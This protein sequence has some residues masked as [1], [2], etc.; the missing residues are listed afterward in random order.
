MTTAYV[1]AGSNLGDR[2]I[3]LATAVRELEHLPETHVE[4]I[5]HVYRSEPAYVEDQEDFFNLV[6]SLETTI[7]ADALLEYLLDIEDRMGREREVPKGPR[8]IDL[9]LLLYGDEEWNSEKLVLPHPLLAERDFVVHPLLEIAPHVRMPDGSRIHRDR[10]TMGK[11]LS[12]EGEL[13]DIAD[14]HDMPID[15]DDWVAV[16]QTESAADAIVGFDASLQFKKAVLEEAG[17]PLA[18][19]PYEPGTEVDPFGMSVTYKIMVPSDRAD[20]AR[21]LLAQ[22]EA[23]PT[24]IPLDTE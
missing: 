2:M 9:D 16:A 19:D 11:V 4:S 22:A 8:V 23:A 3:N 18:F 5:S 17:I 12:D 6:L 10:A 1:G 15:A 20:E 24:D 7:Q 21:A 13:P 14:E